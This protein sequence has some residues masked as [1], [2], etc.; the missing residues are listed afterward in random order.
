MADAKTADNP[1]PNYTRVEE[2]LAED[3]PIIPI[4]HYT[5]VFMLNPQLKGWPVDNVEQNWYSR[6]FYKVAE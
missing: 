1:Q 5:S 3:M 4:Y 6:Q 2:I